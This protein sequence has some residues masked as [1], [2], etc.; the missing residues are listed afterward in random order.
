MG[1]KNER[2]STKTITL[3]SSVYD[4]LARHKRSGESFTKTISRLVDAQESIGT[5][6]DAV[7]AAAAIWA[8]EPSAAEVKAMESVVRSNRSQ[9]FFGIIR[10][11]RR[12]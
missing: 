11:T 1:E 8:K 2:V 9:A 7:R 12:S 5:C 10:A 4:K 3:E 6:G